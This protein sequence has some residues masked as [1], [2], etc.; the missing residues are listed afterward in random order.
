M[1]SFVSFLL[2]LIFSGS[3]WAK[4]DL[5][6]TKRLVIP[7]DHVTPKI[8]S[9]DVAKVVPL[10]LRQ[11]DSE[12]TCLTRI[13]DRGV[14]LWLNSTFM[15]ESSLGRIAEKTQEKLKT[16]VVV[17]ASDPLGVSHRFSFR[18]EAFQALAKFEYSGWLKAAVNYDAK[19]AATDI[20]FKEK[21]FLNKDLVLSHKAS[22]EQD[23]SMI[24]LAWTW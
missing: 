12:G 5:K 9:A 19:A 17:P 24:G 21:V 15:K 20:L 13:A 16:D 18:I 11:G 10:D 8:T 1:K 2:I 22:R 7:V 6:S 14:T 23:F 4:M 3:C